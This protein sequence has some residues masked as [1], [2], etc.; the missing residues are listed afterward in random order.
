MRVGKDL[1]GKPGP[2]TKGTSCWLWTGRGG[3]M[4]RY[5]VEGRKG[6][7]SGK[8]AH[9]VW[10]LVWTHRGRVPAAWTGGGGC[11]GNWFVWQKEKLLSEKQLK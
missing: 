11:V 5:Y 1:K 7:C 4:V 8:G 2:S 6:N 9:E 10:V 3:Y